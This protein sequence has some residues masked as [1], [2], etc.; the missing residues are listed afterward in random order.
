MEGYERGSSSVLQPPD[1]SLASGGLRVPRRVRELER[2]ESGSLVM[3]EAN[4][5]LICEMEGLY[6]FPEMNKK[7]YLHYKVVEHIAGLEKY[8]GLKSLY[9]E[10]NIIAKIEGLDQLA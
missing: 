3:S 4:L 5:K 8:V 6:E 1:L 10:N 9:L 7:I 2:T